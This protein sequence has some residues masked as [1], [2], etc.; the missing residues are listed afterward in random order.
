MNIM[1]N[2]FINISSDSNILFGKFMK[3]AFITQTDKI[4][5]KFFYSSLIN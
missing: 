2:K 5:L 3:C 4:Y 1:Y